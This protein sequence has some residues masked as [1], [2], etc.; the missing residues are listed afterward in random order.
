[1]GEIFGRFVV[2][3]H[4]FFNE[5]KKGRKK[6]FCWKR[7]TKKKRQRK[8]RSTSLIRVALGRVPVFILRRKVR[9]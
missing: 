5:K 7:R 2:G 1:M 8:K 4:F 9:M 3:T 6:I